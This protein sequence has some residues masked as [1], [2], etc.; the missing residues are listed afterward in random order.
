M[1]PINSEKRTRG[2]EVTSEGVSYKKTPLN[3]Q[4]GGIISFNMPQNYN[5]LGTWVVEQNGPNKS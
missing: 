5:K 4:M 3:H 1:N 2:F